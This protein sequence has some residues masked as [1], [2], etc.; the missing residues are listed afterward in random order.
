MN[1]NMK[2]KLSP[3]VVMVP[4]GQS[5][6]VRFNDRYFNLNGEDVEKVLLPI[7]PLLNIGASHSELVQSVDLEFRSKL[8]SVLEQLTSKGWIESKSAVSDTFTDLKNYSSTGL[9]VERVLE[10]FKYKK[11]GIINLDGRLPVITYDV[12]LLIANKIEVEQIQSDTD[13]SGIFEFIDNNDFIV[14]IETETNDFFEKRINSLC[15]SL[16]KPFILFKTSGF[17]AEV[18]PMCIPPYTACLE[19]Y[20]TRK[21]NNLTHYSEHIKV[22]KFLDTNLKGQI[23]RAYSVD[24]TTFRIGF[25][26][27]VGQILQFFLKEDT[28]NFPKTIEGIIEVDGYNVNFN[29]DS[30]LKSP[31]CEVCGQSSKLKVTNKFWTKTY[32]YQE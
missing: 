19:C 14:L 28:W 15:Y 8:S 2:F 20:R 26:I 17:I 10:V 29:Y 6:I 24:S 12:P 22:E 3:G 4:D 18:G 7:L 32:E 25:N 30:L 31:I 5:I 9:N 21:Y 13:F 23:Q 16:Q 1:D 27:L 11:V